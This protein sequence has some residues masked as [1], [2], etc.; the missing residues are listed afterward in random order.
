MKSIRSF[1]LLLRK[2]LM[3]TANITAER[4]SRLG[5]R[6]EKRFGT[7]DLVQKFAAQT[8]GLTM[9]E[10]SGGAEFLVGQWMVADP[11]HFN[12]ERA[13]DLASA[14]GTGWT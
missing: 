10:E 4:P 12:C 5:E 2:A 14:A 8:G 13:R 3:R 6:H 1:A 7:F 11:R 9:I